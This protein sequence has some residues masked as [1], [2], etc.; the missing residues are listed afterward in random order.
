[1]DRKITIADV[2]R[3]ADVSMMTVSR[4]INHKDGVSEGTA[5]RVWAIINRL[6]YRPSGL[7]RGLASNKTRTLGL[8]VPDIGNPFFSDI[9][10]GI[11]YSAYSHGYSVFLCN[12]DEDPQ[13]E[14]AVL[15]S[16]EEK[17]IDGLILCSS[18]LDDEL[19]G[20][21]LKRFPSVVLINRELAGQS[22]RF[23]AVDD[24]TGALQAM[25]H[26]LGAGHRAIG[27]LAGPP[28]SASSVKRMAGYRAA[29]QQAGL[30]IV[31][32]W[33]RHCFPNAE[34]ARD[35]AVRLL[36]EHPEL[37][38]LFCYNDLVAVG[39]L[40]AAM[41]LGRRVPDDLA[42]VGFDDIPLAELITPA[43]TTCRVP[44][45]QLGESAFGLLLHQITGCENDC[46]N[47]ILTP[48]LV[49]RQSTKA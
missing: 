41:S 34:Y 14:Q 26:L 22:S 35:A 40:K 4:V 1:M 15:H 30:E 19:L 18:R 10:R 32:G 12:S 28:V 37:T 44:R 20:E 43:L 38:A 31:P 46:V 9:V 2:A 3:E 25:D 36:T 47:V 49:I 7:A 23:V 21:N 39:A 13:R 8:V 42:L 33:I 5:R 48:E 11:E 27:F 16:L 45:F 17:R 29:F 6:G 24:E